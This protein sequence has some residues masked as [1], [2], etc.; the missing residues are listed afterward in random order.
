[1]S[2]TTD[3]ATASAYS[4]VR[5][6]RGTVLEIAAGEIDK[7][8]SISFLSQYPGEAEF[9]LPP[10]SC[11]E[12]PT[13]SWFAASVAL[14]A[15]RADQQCPPN[16]HAYPRPPPPLPRISRPGPSAP[17]TFIARGQLRL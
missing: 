13:T 6:Q 14:L 10:L 15:R 8:A 11:L 2:T 5:S 16:Q 12:V 17:A 9:L 1:M 4:G 3:R 7:G